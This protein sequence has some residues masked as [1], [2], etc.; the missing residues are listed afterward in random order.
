MGFVLVDGCRE[1]GV[2]LQEVVGDAEGLLGASLERCWESDPVVL[3][4]TITDALV[5]NWIR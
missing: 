2:G 3:N 4:I 5:R 1:G